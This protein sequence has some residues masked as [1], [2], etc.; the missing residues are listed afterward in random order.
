MDRVFFNGKV[1][2]E[3]DRFEEAILVRGDRIALVG[4][5]DEVLA[6]AGDCERV[7]LEG[8]TVIP[9]LNDSHL[10]LQMLGKSLNEVQLYGCTSL[11]EVIRR[12]KE[13][14]ATHPLKDGAPLTGFG[15]NQDYFTDEVRMPNRYDLDQITTDRPVIFS[16]ACGHAISANSYAIEHIG[17]TADSAQPEGG[18]FGITDGE[19]NGL[20]FEHASSLLDPLRVPVTPE[21]LATQLKSGM[22]YAASMGLTTVQSNDLS[23]SNY[24]KYLAAFDILRAKDA[25]TCRYWSQCSF[26]TAENLIGFF[27]EGFKRGSGDNLVQ[28]G[29]VKLFIDGSLGARTA[30]LRG[31]YADDPNALGIKTLADDVFDD[32]VRISDEHNCTV[33]THCIGD[34][35][36]EN[37]INSYAKVIKDG[38]NPNRHGIVHCQIT[39]VPLLERM[40]KLNICALVQPIFIH[41]DMHVVRQRVGDALA[42][43]SYAFGT[44]G[45]MGVPVSY[46]TDCPVEDLNPY[47]NIY[48]AVTRRDLN[49]GEIY[50]EKECVDRFTAIDNYTV[51]SAYTC[52]DENGRGRIKEGFLA[53]FVVLDADIFTVPEDQIRAIR[54]VATYLGGRVAYQR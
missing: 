16:R 53:D 18:E 43:T 14:L 23:E 25:I 12:G 48:C 44:L 26:T 2:V 35:A 6:A 41:Y 1:Y 47:D 39:D 19:P 28:F 5:N 29:S 8:R 49:G 27:S 50:L 54:P 22:D 13:F 9:G 45:R 38:T 17:L 3:R 15:W 24:L 37:C 40:Q 46:G 21:L 31:P 52:F 51:G 10:H 4:K 11:A 33:V 20:F 36:V 30:L 32:I 34:G 7:D 42:D